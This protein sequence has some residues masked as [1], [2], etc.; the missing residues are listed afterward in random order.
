M[1]SFFRLSEKF[2]LLGAMVSDEIPIPSTHEIFSQI[3]KSQPRYLI[4]T[5]SLKCYFGNLVPIAWE[6]GLL[7]NISGMQGMKYQTCNLFNS[8]YTKTN[9]RMHHGV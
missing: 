7:H 9:L 1:I 4:K 5:L 3:K 2:P 6:I 8:N